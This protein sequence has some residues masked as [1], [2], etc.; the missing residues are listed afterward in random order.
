M[1]CHLCED[2][3][4]DCDLDTDA[5]DLDPGPLDQL[6]LLSNNTINIHIQCT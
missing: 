4:M 3:Q 1:S 6:K 5:M 2:G